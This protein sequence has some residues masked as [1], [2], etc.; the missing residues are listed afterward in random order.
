MANRQDKQVQAVVANMICLLQEMT[1]SHYSQYIDAFGITDPHGRANLIDFIKEVL[2]L[3]KDLLVNNTFPLDWNTMIMLQNS[4][5]MKALCQLAHTIRDFFS[6]EF[7]KDT[8]SKFFQCTITFITHPS[9]QLEK[10]SENKRLKIINAY[11]DMRKTMGS[12]V[13]QMWFNLGTV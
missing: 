6:L 9:M 12:G 10:F 5:I 8:W 1:P 2:E 4:V 7:E 11:G 13:K 3:F